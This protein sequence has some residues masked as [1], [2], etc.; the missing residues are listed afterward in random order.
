MKNISWCPCLKVRVNF[1]PQRNYAAQFTVVRLPLLF[2]HPMSKPFLTVCLFMQ[3]QRVVRGAQL[4]A[5]PN[6]DSAVLHIFAR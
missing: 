2:Y 6:F 4:T 1:Y 3:K 5:G